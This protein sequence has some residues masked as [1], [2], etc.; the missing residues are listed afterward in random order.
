MYLNNVQYERIIN[1]QHQI[2]LCFHQ[3]SDKSDK[4]DKSGG[5][6]SEIHNNKKQR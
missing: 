2:N 1:D 3:K 6:M 5:G 4:S